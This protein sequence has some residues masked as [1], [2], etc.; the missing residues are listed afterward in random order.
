MD[1]LHRPDEYPFISDVVDVKK[2]FE[3]SRALKEL[4]VGGGPN[5]MPMTSDVP[6]NQL[7]AQ[8]MGC[9]E[10]MVDELAALCE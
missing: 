10:S 4:V 6:Q 7:L 5:E 1:L 8:R 9:S 2:F 3:E